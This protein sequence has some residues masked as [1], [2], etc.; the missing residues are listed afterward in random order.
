MKF[1]LLLLIPFPLFS[2]TIDSHF[3]PPALH[4][5]CPNY[6]DPVTGEFSQ[7]VNDLTVA[8]VEPLSYH[9]FYQHLCHKSTREGHWNSNP[10][11]KVFFSLEFSDPYFCI[12]EE[13]GSTFVYNHLVANNF[14][15]SS[16]RHFTNQELSGQHNPWNTAVNFHREGKENFS[17]HG[18]VTHGDGSTKTFYSEKKY[19]P[20]KG[21]QYVNVNTP[22]PYPAYVRQKRQPNGNIIEYGY[23]NC[24]L[25]SITA[26]DSHHKWMLGQLN[27]SYQK[28]G[29]KNNHAVQK[30]FITGSDQRNAVL[31]HDIRP[32]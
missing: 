22:P 27:I 10:E 25:V 6:V 4:I 13:S 28:S 26:Y 5:Q 32:D 8:G 30:I 17:Y 7:Y 24:F 11:H 1:F 18:S 9:R 19:W 3:A 12:G 23:N 20:K 31:H 21:A 2:E 16:A 14:G 15:M 29:P